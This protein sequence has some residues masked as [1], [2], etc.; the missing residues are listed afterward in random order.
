MHGNALLGAVLRNQQQR[1]LAEHEDRGVPRKCTATT[2]APALT[3]RVRSTTE[4]SVS[5]VSVIDSSSSP[6]LPGGIS[7]DGEAFFETHWMRGSS[8]AHEAM[9]ISHATQ[10]SKPCRIFS[11][12]RLR[13]MNTMRLSRFSPSFQGRW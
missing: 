9:R 11:S 8:S 5:R 10:L 3:G 7:S 4:G 13:P 1:L 6:G 12:G 2:G